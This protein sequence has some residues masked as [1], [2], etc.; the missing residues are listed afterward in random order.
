MKYLVLFNL[1]FFSNFFFSGVANGVKLDIKVFLTVIGN[2]TVMM[3]AY[4]LPGKMN[5]LEY[6]VRRS[7]SNVRLLTQ[8]I[9]YV[10]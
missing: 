2:K 8:D 4:T 1:L 5:Y 10:F 3:Q 9:K 6:Q 7:W